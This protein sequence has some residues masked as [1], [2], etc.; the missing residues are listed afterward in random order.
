MCDCKKNK[1]QPLVITTIEPAPLSQED[2]DR[3][4]IIEPISVEDIKTEGE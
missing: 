1:R 4:D 2:K 3:L